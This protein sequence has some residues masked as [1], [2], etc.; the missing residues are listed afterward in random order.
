MFVEHNKISLT[1][2]PVAG[3]INYNS[4]TTVIPMTQIPPHNTEA[5]VSRQLKIEECL[6]QNMAQLSYDRIS[7]A[8][9]C[10]QMEKKTLNYISATIWN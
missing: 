10:R 7:V 6:L 8:D 9:L 3:I 1:L 2:S 4:F 5:A